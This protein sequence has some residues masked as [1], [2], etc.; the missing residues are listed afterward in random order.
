VTPEGA[1]DDGTAEE[2]DNKGGDEYDGFMAP[3][4]TRGA[5]GS[6]TDAPTTPKRDADGNR[7]SLA[8]G[9]RRS[10]GGGHPRT[11]FDPQAVDKFQHKADSSVDKIEKLIASQTDKI[12]KEV[13]ALREDFQAKLD[14]MR[15]GQRRGGERQKQE[16]SQIVETLQKAVTNLASHTTDLK[17]ATPL[18][19]AADEL[20]QASKTLTREMVAAVQQAKE[21]LDQGDD[22]GALLAAQRVEQASDKMWKLTK[23]PKNKYSQ[24]SS[25]LKQVY[26]SRDNVRSEADFEKIAEELCHNCEAD[27][28]SMPHQVCRCPFDHENS[29]KPEVNDA[30]KSPMARLRTI[31][32]RQQLKEQA[33]DLMKGKKLRPISSTSYVRLVETASELDDVTP[34]V[35]YVQGLSEAVAQHGVPDDFEVFLTTVDEFESPDR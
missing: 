10:P 8:G 31:K 33:E 1:P 20:K 7:S 4:T 3:M 2:L 17:H 9:V 13:S 29:N 14:G 35:F 28:P 30:Q 19:T 25:D 6:S 23:F 15:E 18:K 11:R 26:A 32:R 5:Q 22:V 21:C 27:A 16:L 24:F 12:S 34:G